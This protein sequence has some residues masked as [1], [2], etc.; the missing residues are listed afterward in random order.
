MRAKLKMEEDASERCAVSWPC[1]ASWGQSCDYVLV[2]SLVVM[3]GLDKCSG[4]HCGRLVVQ[5][6]SSLVDVLLTLVWR[7]EYSC[8]IPVPHR[9]MASPRVL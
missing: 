6:C 8:Q 9:F 2:C 4:Q 5:V 3:I 1:L 7:S